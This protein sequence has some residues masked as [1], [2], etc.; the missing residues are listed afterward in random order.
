MK[1]PMLDL[2]RQQATF[3]D[4]PV[5]LVSDVIAT[6]QYLNNK[7]PNSLQIA[8]CG[9]LRPAVCGKSRVGPARSNRVAFGGRRP[10][11]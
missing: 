2:P 3:G 5:E 1:V 6:G 9:L 10:G 11:G 4:S 7:W 8:I